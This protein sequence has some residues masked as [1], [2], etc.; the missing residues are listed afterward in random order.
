MLYKNTVPPEARKLTPGVDFSLI[1]GIFW[2]HFG[3]MSGHW[4]AKAMLFTACVCHRFY[5]V[6][7]VVFLTGGGG[8]GRKPTPPGAAHGP[9]P[10]W[11]PGKG[12][13]GDSPSTMTWVDFPFRQRGK[14]LPLRRGKGLPFRQGMGLPFRKRQPKDNDNDNLSHTP[15]GRRI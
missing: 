4:G 10:G 13:E 7:F 11:S 14:G 2:C 5:S 3:D 6:L 1:L 9:P 8:R 15:T 12:R